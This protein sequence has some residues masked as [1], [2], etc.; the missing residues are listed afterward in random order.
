MLINCFR[1]MIHSTNVGSEEE[2]KAEK[3]KSKA[4]GDRRMDKAKAEEKEAKEK[5][6]KANNLKKFLTNNTKFLL[7]NFLLGYNN[8]KLQ[9]LPK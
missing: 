2:K 6:D 4:V 1:F 5:K 3:E 8:G 9:L 7:K